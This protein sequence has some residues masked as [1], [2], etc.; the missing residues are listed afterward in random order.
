MSFEYY[1]VENQL[2][3]LIDVRVNYHVILYTYSTIMLVIDVIE[4]TK[5]KRQFAWMTLE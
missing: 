4:I 1:K 5:S 3:I 2:S